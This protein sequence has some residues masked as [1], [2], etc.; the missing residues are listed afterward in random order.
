MIDKRTSITSIIASQNARH[1][2]LETVSVADYIDKSTGETADSATQYSQ[3]TDSS[4]RRWPVCRA[5]C[6]L[7]SK[8]LLLYWLRRLLAIIQLTPHIRFVP[9]LQ[10][11]TRSLAFRIGW[12]SGQQNTA[13][14]TWQFPGKWFART[15]LPWRPQGLLAVGQSMG[16]LSWHTRTL[17]ATI[18]QATIT[19][20]S[21]GWPQVSWRINRAVWCRARPVELS[22]KGV[23]GTR[24]DCSL[25]FLNL[26]GGNGETC[27]LVHRYLSI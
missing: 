23:Q 2:Y 7:R 15:A 11:S 16:G 25:D 22:F 12:F 9:I 3:V 5:V 26:H 21:C 27:Q 24:N 6:P 18:L 4:R 14:P 1:D 13:I 20:Y 19:L 17:Q 10:A 8:W